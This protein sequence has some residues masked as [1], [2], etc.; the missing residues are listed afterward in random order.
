MIRIRVRGSRKQLRGFLIRGHAGFG[1]AGE[2]IV[3]AGVSALATTALYG[4]SRYLPGKFSFS[5]SEEGL[6]FC[7]LHIGLLTKQEAHDAQVIFTVLL[8]GLEGVA[9]EYGRYVDLALQEVKHHDE[10]ESA[11]VC[12]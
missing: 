11:A 1:K 7:K 8:L 6:L 2:D 12:S 10:D 9:R 3:C 5:R 4:L